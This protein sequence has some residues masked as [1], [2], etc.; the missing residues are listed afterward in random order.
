MKHPGKFI[1]ICTFLILLNLAPGLA[2][3]GP[4]S[5]RVEVVVVKGVDLPADLIGGPI[6]SYRVFAS[7][8][9]ELSAIPMQIDEKGSDGE[10]LWQV[11]PEA[12]GAD[13]NF[14]ATDELVFMAF[15]S[16]E[17]HVGEIH[18][19]CA[20]SATITVSDTKTGAKGHV[21]LA[22]C[23][24]PPPLS[25]SVYVNADYEKNMIA[26]KAYKIGWEEKI[27]YS[28]DYLSMGDGPDFIDRLKIRLSL[29]KFGLNYVV[30]EEDDLD[31]KHQGYVAGPVRVVV[32][33][34][35]MVTVGP[36]KLNF[37]APLTIQCY[38]DYI[39]IIGGLELNFNPAK[40]GLDFSLAISHDMILDKLPG[41]KKVCIN[42]MPECRDYD[43]KISAEKKKELAAMDTVWGGFEGPDGALISYYAGDKRLSTKVRGIYV[44]DPGSKNPPDT[45]KGENPLIGFDVVEW[46][47][48]KPEF[49]YLVFYHFF[50]P[51][52]SVA[53]VDRHARL[54]TQPLSVS[55][56]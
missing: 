33:T 6:T 24:S 42:N 35:N 4:L 48:V 49:Y 55:V 40:L 28:Y 41:K 53:E 37:R 13:G 7:D 18:E 32:K 11:G 39:H 52:Y 51:E 36:F 10:L 23:D 2:G 22:R 27:Y 25:D 45:F 17:A 26:G 30:N 3:A 5:D 8:G 16:R 19:G 56:E 29:G 47:N 20:E 54:E 14:D 34:K 43:N 15:D 46:D 12:R 31:S 21:I 50:M 9:T 38:R 44:D 1:C